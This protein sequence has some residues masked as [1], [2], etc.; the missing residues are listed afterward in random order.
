MGTSQS[1]TSC[2]SLEESIRSEIPSQNIITKIH[3][4]INS[5][6]TFT[7]KCLK[8]KLKS[9]QI[10]RMLS[11]NYDTAVISN[12]YVFCRSYLGLSDRPR[13]DN[14]N[15]KSLENITVVTMCKKIIAMVKLMN[16]FIKKNQIHHRIL[17]M[18]MVLT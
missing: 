1:N 15:Y 18:K 9:D 11:A 3:L 12:T 6:L 7:Y 5:V 10:V 8:D 13:R 16:K 2:K 14:I 17:L 4:A